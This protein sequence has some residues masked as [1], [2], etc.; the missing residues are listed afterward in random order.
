M[1]DV[2]PLTNLASQDALS[3]RALG[4]CC[5]PANALVKQGDTVDFTGT[6]TSAPQGFAARTGLTQA[7]G[8][9]QLTEQRYLRVS[10]PSSS[11]KLSR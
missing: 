5:S 8:A 1:N 2:A 3:R 9:D 10:V 4:R 6:V 7:E 11:V